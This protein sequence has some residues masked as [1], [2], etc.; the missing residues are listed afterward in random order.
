[1][2]RRRQDRNM[3]RDVCFASHNQSNGPAYRRRRLRTP[4]LTFKRREH[5]SPGSFT[6]INDDDL[7]LAE[8]Y[9]TDSAMTNPSSPW[10]AL[11]GIQGSSTAPGITGGVY[12]AVSSTGTFAPSF[13]IHAS[14]SKTASAMAAFVNG[15]PG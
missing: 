14:T 10:S 4:S 13:S 7:V 11:Q 12:Q 5:L 15:I 8:A 1:M 9:T 6:T 2:R 3:E